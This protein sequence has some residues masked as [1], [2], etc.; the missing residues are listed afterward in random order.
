M[1]RIRSKLRLNRETVRVLGSQEL[2]RIQGG[3]GRYCVPEDTIYYPDLTSI[4]YTNGEEICLNP[5]ELSD[6]C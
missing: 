2:S 3:T 5:T 1:S 4:Q 6:L